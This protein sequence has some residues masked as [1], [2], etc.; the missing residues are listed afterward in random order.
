MDIDYYYIQIPVLVQ[1]SVIPNLQVKLGPT[2]GFAVSSTYSATETVEYEGETE[3]ETYDDDVPDASTFDFGLAAG[4]G[5]QI[6]NE[7]GLDARFEYGLL[8][9][10]DDF[11][12]ANFGFGL[13]VSYMFLSL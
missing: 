8:D 13:N 9:V 7:F 1:Y 2:F 10:A 11:K 5:Y 3:K 12:C 4:I 6:T